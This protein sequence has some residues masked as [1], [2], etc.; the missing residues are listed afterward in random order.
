MKVTHISMRSKTGKYH[1]DNP[2]ING[3][4][5]AC[6]WIATFHSTVNLDVQSLSMCLIE[7]GRFNS[8][9]KIPQEPI[10][11]KSSQVKIVRNNLDQVEIQDLKFDKASY[12]N[13]HTRFAIVLIDNFTLE[14]VCCSKSFAVLS[15]RRK[16]PIVREDKISLKRDKKTK[17]K[18][19]TQPSNRILSTQLPHEETEILLPK[20][21]LLKQISNI[22]NMVNNFPSPQCPSINAP[23]LNILNQ[24]SPFSFPCSSFFNNVC[25]NPSSAQYPHP[26]YSNDLIYP[27]S[28]DYDECSGYQAEDLNNNLNEVEVSVVSSPSSSD[29]SNQVNNPYLF[30]NTLPSSLDELPLPDLDWDLNL[31][32]EL[33]Q[34]SPLQPL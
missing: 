15:R 9:S 23:S 12:S 26:S 30:T 19:S 4:H 25:S 6:T 24:P 5:K 14:P 33:D 7:K 16:L 34:Y 17:S 32:L 18:N 10:L 27:S 2:E 11:E 31:D 1:Y 22:C 8:S 13:M 3:I 20:Q 29:A 21:L 28:L